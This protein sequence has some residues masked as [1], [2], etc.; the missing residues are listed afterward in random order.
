MVEPPEHDR[1]MASRGYFETKTSAAPRAEKETGIHAHGGT[2][3]EDSLS[4]WV[5]MARE[6]R[7]SPLLAIETLQKS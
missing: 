5:T 7:L 6:N 2:F 1:I 3:P 4:C